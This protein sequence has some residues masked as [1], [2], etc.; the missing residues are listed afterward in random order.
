MTR[1]T[2]DSFDPL[3]RT[4]QRRALRDDSGR[5]RPESEPEMFE[6]LARE[7]R[8]RHRLQRRRRLIGRVLRR[9]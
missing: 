2:R 6:R 9:E 4:V 3:L 5:R 8:T 7:A 1:D